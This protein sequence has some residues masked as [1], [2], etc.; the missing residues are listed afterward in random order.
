MWL[1]YLG[2]RLWTWVWSS[3]AWK[4]CVYVIRE[5]TFA[6]EKLHCKRLIFHKASEASKVHRW[7]HI[8]HM[9][10]TLPWFFHQHWLVMTLCT[11]H[12]LGIPWDDWQ[13]GLQGFSFCEIL[14]RDT[15]RE[16]NWVCCIV[17]VT[18]LNT[19]RVLGLGVSGS[20]L[21]MNRIKNGVIKWSRGTYQLEGAIIWTKRAEEVVVKFNLCSS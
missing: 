2:K 5:D 20:R 8:L 17:I 11:S 14:Q 12:L 3:N 13:F 21:Y 16:N 9:G 1:N 10:S 4:K 19:W 15:S 6:R 7:S 18:A